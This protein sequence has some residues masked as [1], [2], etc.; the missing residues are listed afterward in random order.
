MWQNAVTEKLAVY[1]GN[2]KT[3]PGAKAAVHILDSAIDI[4]LQKII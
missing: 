4:Q 3:K 1:A 2:V